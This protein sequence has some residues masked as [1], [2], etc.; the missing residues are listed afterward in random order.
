MCVPQ[1]LQW[2]FRRMVWI[3]ASLFNLFALATSILFLLYFRTRSSTSSLAIILFTLVVIAELGNR[4]LTI[5]LAFSYCAKRKHLPKCVVG[6]DGRERYPPTWGW[7]ATGVTVLGGPPA[8]YLWFEWGD[9]R[10][11]KRG[12][13]RQNRIIIRTCTAI[14]RLLFITAFSVS[15]NK[16]LD[17]TDVIRIAIAV[18][19][20]LICSFLAAADLFSLLLL[21]I[22]IRTGIQIP[23]DDNE[24]EITFESLRVSTPV[25]ARYH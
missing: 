9:R 17:R 22:N 8:A 10:G 3:V 12:F 25:P 23:D 2:K 19:A 15:L 5:L 7:V 18:F 4:F 16:N 14:L 21:L 1:P 11:P 6:R 24:A 13:I 20:V